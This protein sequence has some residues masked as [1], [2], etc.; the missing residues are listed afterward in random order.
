MIRNE[1]LKEAFET[2]SKE[3]KMRLIQSDDENK[4]LNSVKRELE[5]AKNEL[6][7]K[8]ESVNVNYFI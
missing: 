5:K 8:L 2:E 1:R 3:L 7:D 4:R 6:E